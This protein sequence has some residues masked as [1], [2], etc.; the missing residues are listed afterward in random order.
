MTFSKHPE[1]LRRAIGDMG[2]NG[3]NDPYN[4][5]SNKNK[6]DSILIRYGL[7]DKE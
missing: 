2:T 7:A 6:V 5:I 1:T 4:N 3:K